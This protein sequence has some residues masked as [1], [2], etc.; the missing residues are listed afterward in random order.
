MPSAVV[1]NGPVV[2][3]ISVVESAVESVARTS[4]LLLPTR[5]ER[6]PETAAGR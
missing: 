2:D 4:L 1:F 5:A 6:N 3:V